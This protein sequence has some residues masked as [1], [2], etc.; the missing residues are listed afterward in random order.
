MKL[1]QIEQRLGL[2]PDYLREQF[3]R[4]RRLFGF[5]EIKARR[6]RTSPEELI[7]RLQQQGYLLVDDNY[8]DTTYS[9]LSFDQWLFDNKHY[10]LVDYAVYPEDTGL[11]DWVKNEGTVQRYDGMQ[12][13][14]LNIWEQEEK[15]IW[16]NSDPNTL[17]RYFTPAYKYDPVDQWGLPD[18]GT[19]PIY[20][21]AR[22]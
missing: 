20:S 22:P 1:E 16:R 8:Y 14:S 4:D 13:H 21:Y 2:F 15:D 7:K 18:A 19:N 9:H 11:I 12:H 5:V 17:R 10:D 3:D 6:I